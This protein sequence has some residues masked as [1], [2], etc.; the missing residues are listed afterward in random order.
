LLAA[1]DGRPDPRFCQAI[2]LRLFLVAEALGFDSLLME[3][4]R[5]FSVGTS[6]GYTIHPERFAATVQNWAAS[7][8]GNPDVLVPY[9]P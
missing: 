3:C 2:V 6:A 1:Y 7:L 9:L 5:Y 4:T 8:P